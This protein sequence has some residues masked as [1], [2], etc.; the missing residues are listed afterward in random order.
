MKYKPRFGLMLFTAL[1]LLAA[2]AVAARPALADDG[3]P[4][5]VETPPVEVTPP[6]EG[7]APAA[8][9]PIVETPPVEVAPPVAT[10]TPSEEIQPT[11]VL[12]QL[13]EDTEVIVLDESGEVTPLATTTA[14]QAIA[15]G[16]PQWCPVGV[17]PNSSSC[18]TA[19]QTSFA[20]LLAEL[21]TY[22]SGAGPNKA[23]VIWIEASYDSGTND[24]GAPG[25]TLDG[26]VLTAMANYALTIQGGWTGV[27]KIVNQF[28]PSEFNTALSI[29]DWKGAVTINDI[30]VSGVASNPNP[31]KDAALYVET[32]Q[33]IALNRVQATGNSLSGA[34]LDNGVGVTPTKQ[35][36][37]T[38]NNSAFNQ[39]SGSGLYVYSVG[40]ITIRNLVANFNGTDDSA[41][42][43][44]AFITNW[45]LFNGNPANK[46][47]TIGGLNQFSGNIGTG[48]FVSSSNVVTLSNITA[49]GNIGADAVDDGIGVKVDSS[50]SIKMTGSNLFNDN[51][52]NGL[53]LS[54]NGAIT[55]NNI[56][57]SN[58]GFNGAYVDNCL[59]S[60]ANTPCTITGKSVILTGAN[61]F[62]ANVQYGLAIVSGGAV[63]TSQ[64]TAN[65]N[66]V[67]AGVSI[68]NC[69]T[70]GTAC[71]NAPYA[72]TLSAPS[73]FLNNELDGLRIVTAGAVTLKGVTA[74]DNNQYGVYIDNRASLTKPQKVTLSGTN[75]F[76]DNDGAGL[77]I[78]SYG[79]VTLSNVTANKNGHELACNTCFGV[80]VDNSGYEVGPVASVLKTRQPITLTG[81]NTFN[82]NYYGGASF[83]SVGAVTLTNVTAND[84]LGPIGVSTGNGVYVRNVYAWK[85][86]GINPKLYQANVTLNGF[87]I[88]ENNANDGLSVQTYGAIKLNNVTANDNDDIGLYLDNRVSDAVPTRQPITLAGI[89]TFNTNGGG[90]T[91][92]SFGNIVLSNLT[93]VGNLAKAPPT[94]GYGQG[95]YVSND[96]PWSPNGVLTAYAASVTLS[97]FG[98]FE[99]NI[100]DGLNIHSKGVVMLASVTSNN[101]GGNGLYISNTGDV[102]PQNVTLTKSNNFSGNTG[103][104][105]YVL[106]DGK[107]TVSNI[108]AI[109]NDGSGAQF[110]NF[111]DAKANKFLG[112]TITGVNYFQR[113]LGP[114][115]LYIHSAGA[116]SVS[117][118]YADDN[119]GNGVEIITTK[120]LTLLCAN[121]YSNTGTGF[122]LTSGTGSVMT[123]KGVFAF[124]NGTNENLTHDPL[125]PV[126][127]AYCP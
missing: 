37:V 72:V 108:T 35:Y 24:P 41:I 112:V 51:G 58:N 62:N 125:K 57:A 105:I 5:V 19:G 42:D 56:N 48:L 6:V 90:V 39:N 43:Y 121:A 75:T 23:G 77:K 50:A 60:G 117:N 91:M 16:D 127:R 8:L 11:S 15:T 85:P 86:D 114:N 10:E 44:G 98:Y 36:P 73:V 69:A 66:L 26:M 79:A 67:G 53:Q 92:F 2:S 87:G 94:S 30:V 88:F 74:N 97:G 111:T 63:T 28:D 106:T 101:N 31:G 12:E 123:L 49:S 55:L 107:I 61:V 70:N 93:A 59:N 14:A 1:A 115:G 34:I 27:G 32:V 82:G 83:N 9:P 95:V 119:S 68:D 76:I 89:N 17:T 18:T 109:D 103:D 25:F 20:G 21:S 124:A 40:A 7:E 102:A 100:G 13:P 113:N 33:S 65:D 78:Y 71:T 96:N 46:P 116:V 104:G 126:V 47:L 45:I 118:L 54:S 3:I 80:Y 64:V 4:P 29:L 110:D 120:S 52:N 99:N 38:V 122:L 22:N 81:F 84:N